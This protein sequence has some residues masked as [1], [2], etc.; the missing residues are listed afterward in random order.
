M[1]TLLTGPPVALIYVIF[2]LAGVGTHG[3]QCLIIAAVASYYPDYLRGGTALGWALGV[4]RIG[5]VAAPQI[6]GW[7]LAAGL[8]ADSN[9]ILFGVSA[10]VAA[11][12]L[13]VIWRRFPSPH[14]SAPR[15][16]ARIATHMPRTLETK[17]LSCRICR[18]H[19]SSSP[20][21]GS[22]ARP[23]PWLSP[24]SANVTLFERAS[25][26]GEVGAGLQVGPHG[27]RIL[28]SWG[29]LDDVL[30]RA[31]LPKNIV[32][33]DAITAEV[34]TT[35]DLGAEFRARYGGPYFVTHRSD[36]HATLVDAARAA[37]AELHTG[38]TVTDVITDGDK[39]T[40]GTDDGC[41]HEADIALG[42]D[43][44]KSRLRG[45]DLGRRTRV[46][47]LRRLPG[48]HP[49]PGRR[50]RRGHRGCG[51]LHRTA[52]PLHPVP[53][54][55][56]RNAQPGRGVRI[57]RFQERNRELGV[58]PRS[59]NRPTRTATR[60]SAA[61]STTCGRTGG[62]RCTTASRSRT[63]WTGG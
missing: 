44:L 62:G 54:A 34:L 30:S 51:R 8:G 55:R 36:L 2:V 49:V 59:S 10:L 35:I 15:A 40:V 16:L 43:G 45:E 38:V 20:E 26:F 28:D 57:A 9:F 13:T 58:D 46:L 22:V 21:A 29:V 60:T 39:V 12:L 6:G 18:T 31:F 47:R 53:A 27:A 25:E 33:R 1:L 23:T 3:T 61:G 32:F 42:M 56:R 19:A 5:A 17:E 52:V 11:L 4:G 24:G 14:V 63:G 50:T 41:R 7:L 37:G 48:H